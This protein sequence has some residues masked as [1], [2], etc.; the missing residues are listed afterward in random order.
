MIRCRTGAWSDWRMQTTKQGQSPTVAGFAV[1]KILRRP[2][3]FL[4][5]G[6]VRMHKHALV[7]TARSKWRLTPKPSACGK[8]T[9]SDPRGS[10]KGPLA[11]YRKIPSRGLPLT[12]PPNMTEQIRSGR[13]T[14]PKP[15]L[16]GNRTEGGTSHSRKHGYAICNSR[17]R[18]GGAPRRCAPPC[19]AERDGRSDLRQQAPS[20]D[21]PD[22]TPCGWPCSHARHPS[23]QSA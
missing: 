2:T 22:A 5:D 23:G 11:R 10:P 4:Q 8:T 20:R 17:M 7:P 15:P 9:A 12:Q 3:F 14:I 6:V 18:K 1:T 13:F 19:H 21:A 16:T